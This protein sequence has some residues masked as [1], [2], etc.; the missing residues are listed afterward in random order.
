MVRSWDEKRARKPIPKGLSFVGMAMATNPILPRARDDGL[1]NVFESLDGR[2]GDRLNLVLSENNLSSFARHILI[3][4]DQIV[5][6]GLIR[7]LVFSQSVERFGVDFE[8][9]PHVVGHD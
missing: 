2:F 8:V 7:I 3:E 6:P 5:I 1:V 4:P 9:L